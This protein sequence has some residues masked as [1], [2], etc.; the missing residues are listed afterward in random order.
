LS[1]SG[2]AIIM[3]QQWRVQ[4]LYE[5]MSLGPCCH[6]RGGESTLQ[7]QYSSH[8]SGFTSSQYLIKDEEGTLELSSV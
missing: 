3:L 1:Y 2:V 6:R 4:K 7:V 5:T 8:V